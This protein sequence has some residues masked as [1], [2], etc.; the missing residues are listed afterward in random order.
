MIDHEFAPLGLFAQSRGPARQQSDLALAEL[1]VDGGIVPLQ[2]TVF[3]MVV[4]VAI[5]ALFL[6]QLD[7]PV[8]V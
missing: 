8:L 5:A 2:A 4:V 6:T 1:I 7:G 3:L